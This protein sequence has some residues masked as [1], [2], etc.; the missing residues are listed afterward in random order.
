MT[1]FVI[2]ISH[3]EGPDHLTRMHDL[4]EIIEKIIAKN[5][6]SLS[7]LGTGFRALHERITNII[8]NYGRHPHRNELLGRAS[9]AA[10]LQY[11]A[12]GDFP[13]LQKDD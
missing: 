3:C 12:T 5:P 1:F 4:D 9:S 11:I 10:E 2:S 7:E 6:D 13:H 8:A